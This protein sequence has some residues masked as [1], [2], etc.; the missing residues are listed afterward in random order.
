MRTSSDAW[1]SAV[2]VA[3][4]SAAATA[5]KLCSCGSCAMLKLSFSELFRHTKPR[6]YD[7]ENV[8][9]LSVITRFEADSAHAQ[10]DISVGIRLHNS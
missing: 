9:T 8:Y 7:K 2:G 3:G 10:I 5:N 1:D 4:T 6:N